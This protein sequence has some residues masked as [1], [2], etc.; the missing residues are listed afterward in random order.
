MTGG[1]QTVTRR[2]LARHHDIRRQFR[3]RLRRSDLL[4]GLAWFSGVIAIALFLGDGG[5]AYFVRPR[6]ITTG[7]GILAG[8]MG[9]DLILVMLLLA[10]RLPL[11]DKAVGYD[12]AMATHRRLA[13]PAFFLLLAHFALLILGYG[14]A[15]DLDPLSQAL[16]FS[17]S[18]PDMAFAFAA[19][20]LVAIVIVSSLVIVRH[21]L[22]YQLWFGIHLLTYAA[23]VLGIP[24]Q[25]SEGSL[26][27]PGTAARWYWAALYVGSLASLTIFRI[28]IPLARSLRHS[29]RI[30]AIDP[31]APDVASITVEGRHLGRL[32][33][34]AG[35][36]FIWRFAQPGLRWEG[37]PYS[38]SA[39]PD[40]K[41][42]RITVRSLGD[43]SRRLIDAAARGRVFVEGPYGLFTTR[44]CTEQNAVL[45]GAWIGVTP[46]CALLLCVSQGDDAR[47]MTRDD[48]LV[49]RTD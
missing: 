17:T 20:G 45:I 25:F 32:R 9:S 16:R 18:T 41:H 27:A 39:A 22:K 1:A 31:E 12:R 23:V 35:Q 47:G 11:I 2:S 15:L 5:A 49:T 28:I 3:V 26:F 13:K 29:L 24:H 33:A 46:V 36:F 30:T 38:L 34:R 48:G 43:S 44:A 40:G 14:I 37:H 4:Q 7:L 10:S 21:R 42:L 8:L 6:D 19:L